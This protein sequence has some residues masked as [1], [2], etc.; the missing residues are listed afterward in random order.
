[1]VEDFTSGGSKSTTEPCA[2]IQQR[3]WAILRPFT[4]RSS[5]STCAEQC[6]HLTR[7]TNFSTMDVGG[8]D[9]P[10]VPFCRQ[11]A[12]ADEFW[13]RVPMSAS[14]GNMLHIGTNSSMT[15]R[16]ADLA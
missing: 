2:H 12:C 14:V 10:F 4:R 7:M 16:S 1:M 15:R 3:I 11:L 9:G 6:R 8:R 13:C 5:S